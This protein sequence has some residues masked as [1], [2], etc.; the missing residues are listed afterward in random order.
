LAIFAAMRRASIAFAESPLGN[1][2]GS[3]DRGEAPKAGD[4]MQALN[5]SLRVAAGSLSR[6]EVQADRY[7]HAWR[8]S[9]EDTEVAAAAV[10]GHPR[11]FAERVRGRGIV[12]ADL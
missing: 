10:K 2:E 6:G 7:A 5:H 12:P 11:G 4:G 8:N 1:S 3:F 9:D